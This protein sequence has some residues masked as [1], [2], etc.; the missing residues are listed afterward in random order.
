MFILKR[1]LAALPIGVAVLVLV[2]VIIHIVPGNPVDMILGPY[3]T[4]ADK[5]ALM[6]DLGLDRS[7]QSQVVAYIS[8]VFRGDLGTS[9]IYHEPVLEL[10]RERIMPTVELAIFSILVAICISLPLGIIA[11]LNRGGMADFSAMLLSLLGVAIPNFWFGPL[12]ILF[13]SVYLGWLPVSERTG[14]L[15]Y[16]LP[17][18]TLGTSLASILTRMTRNSFLDNLRQDYVRTAKAKGLAPKRVLFKHVLRNAA[19]PL[20]TILGLQ[21]GV[22]LTGAIITEKV[23]DW[24]GLGTLLVESLNNRDYPVLQGCILLFSMTYL[25]VNLATDICYSLIDPRIRYE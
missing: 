18:L 19:I 1:L 8:G 12:L 9:L 7:V 23:F 5:L 16:V 14:A 15:S 10:L 6:H 21:F 2:G 22:L 20:T 11:A 24:P 25:V 4:E 17:S 13:F 3:A